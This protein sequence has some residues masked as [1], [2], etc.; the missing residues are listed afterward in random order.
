LLIETLNFQGAHISGIVGKNINRTE[1]KINV[2]IG[3]D[4]ASPIFSKRKE[5][6]RLTKDDANY[7]EVIHSNTRGF[8]IYAPLGHTDIYLNGKAEQ[9][10]CIAQAS[11]YTRYN[12]CSHQRAVH[13][14]V[15]ALKSKKILVKP[16]RSLKDLKKKCPYGDRFCIWGETLGRNYDLHGI[17][18]VDTNDED[19]FER[20]GEGGL[21]GYNN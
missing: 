19:S 16:C 11:F 5:K 10:E 15:E 20:D 14:Y 17:Y 7:V 12:K 4:P 2:I 6:N 21:C 1:S 9:P 18:Y 3:L 8:G 13:F